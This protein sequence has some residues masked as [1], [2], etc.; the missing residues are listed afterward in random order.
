MLPRMSAP[1]PARLARLT[2]LA[3]LTSLVTNAACVGRRHAYRSRFD[4]PPWAG[5]VA[6]TTKWHVADLPDNGIKVVILPEPSAPTIT[7]VTRLPIGAKDDPLGKAGLAHLAEHAVFLKRGDDGRTIQDAIDEVAVWNNAATTTMETA[8]YTSVLPSELGAALAIQRRLLEDPCASID[9]D[10]FAIEREVVLNELRVRGIDEFEGDP[11]R[12]IPGLKFPGGL[13]ADVAKATVADTCHFI[14][15]YYAA[16]QAVVVIAGP[17]EIAAA[18]QAAVAHL[19]PAAARSFVDPRPAPG[20]T[21]FAGAVTGTSDDGRGEALVLY[22][23]PEDPIGSP[24]LLPFLAANLKVALEAGVRPGWA[25]AVHVAHSNGFG[26][27][28]ITVR[29]V[30]RKGQRPEAAQAARWI[31]AA[32]DDA[33]RRDRIGWGTDANWVDRHANDVQLELEPLL[34]RALRFAQLVAAVTP[35]QVPRA[36]EPFEMTAATAKDW[37]RDLVK[38]AKA[39]LI[40]L[41]P[42]PP[43]TAAAPTRRHRPPPRRS[44]LHG[45]QSLVDALH[46]GRGS[47]SAVRLPTDPLPGRHARSFTLANGLAVHLEDTGAASPVTSVVLSVAFGDAHGGGDARI[48]EALTVAPTVIAEET[49]AVS[50]DATYYLLQDVSRDLPALL[51][52]AR[53]S[54]FRP[55]IL[56]GRISDR[57]RQQAQAVERRAITDPDAVVMRRLFGAAHPYGRAVK[58]PGARAIGGD[59]VRRLRQRHYRPDAAALYVVGRFDLDQAEAQ[60]RHYLGGWSPGRD[61]PPA[62]DMPRPAPRPGLAV[63]FDPEAGNQ[64]EIHLAFPTAADSDAH[65]PGRLVLAEILRQ[66]AALLREAEGITYGA[67]VYTGSLRW[68]GYLKLEVSVDPRHGAAAV[69]SL[70]RLVDDLRDR[71]PTDEELG[72]AKR[73]VVRSVF[74]GDATS[75][76]RAVALAERDVLGRR[77]TD[78]ALLAAVAALTADEVR[79]RAIQELAPTARVLVLSGRRANVAATIA[80][81]RRQPDETITRPRHDDDDPDDD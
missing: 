81:L 1:R 76:G 21:G 63:V 42:E 35:E 46:A 79:D 66:R 56:G 43:A 72:L 29:L 49:R 6:T 25:G 9:P 55:R 57:L 31:A 14:D 68:G 19:G 69:V 17:V 8:F 22:R 64:T 78:E 65:R 38:P 39:R 75:G 13:E 34:H 32:V 16:S 74:A 73:V 5:A 80:A 51:Q 41:E 11:S 26:I 40:T 10:G 62:L 44:K 58:V 71:G 47:A 33:L 50:P 15:G 27:R 18:M 28:L 2:A 3:G 37:L 54:A 52:V 45:S 53:E 36:F 60:I 61:A 23:L 12:F 48:V 7:V 70:E 59:D 24:Q 30:A 20:A 77:Q 67:E 4:G